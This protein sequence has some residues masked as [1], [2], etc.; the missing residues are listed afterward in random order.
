MKL[1]STAGKNGRKVEP[2]IINY[3]FCSFGNCR[4]CG[5][6]CNGAAVGGFLEHC[7]SHFH[8]SIFF[9]SSVENLLEVIFVSE[10]LKA[11]DEMRLA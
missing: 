8:S 6:W 5:I 4:I 10:C 9:L 2:I 3:F 11:S 1:K 7:V